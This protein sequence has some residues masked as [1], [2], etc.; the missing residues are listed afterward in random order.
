MSDF[1]NKPELLTTTT[2]EFNSTASLEYNKY[3][4]DIL[5]NSELNS[6]VFEELPV[7]FVGKNVD[8]TKISKGTEQL[9]EIMESYQTFK[10]LNLNEEFTS[11]VTN[12]VDPINFL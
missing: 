12:D 7:I 4:L 2:R 1:I 10:E 9:R 5:D 3:N 8:T 6:K 11:E